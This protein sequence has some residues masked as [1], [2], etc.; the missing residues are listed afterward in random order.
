MRKLN[1]LLILTALI[2]FSAC[3]KSRESGNEVMYEYEE[4]IGKLSPALKARIGSW[5]EE[6][7]VCYGCV[8]AIDGNGNQ[9]NGKP[10]KAKILSFNA[11]SI[12]MKALENVSVA[13]G[14][15]EGCSKM[16]ISRGETWWETE[17]DIFQSQNEAEAYLREK[18]LL[19]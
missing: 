14:V 8:V 13:E 16:G 18:G 11:D 3:N 4:E 10:V 15:A 12:K 17:G 6:G 7:A 2:I 1:L 9:I 19:K 5:A